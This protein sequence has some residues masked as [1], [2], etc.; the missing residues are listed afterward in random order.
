MPK[1]RAKAIPRRTALPEPEAFYIT[2]DLLVSSRASLAPLAAAL[3]DAHLPMARLLVL[4]GISRGSVETDFRRFIARLSVLR[5]AALRSWRTA[6]RRVLDIGVQAGN[7][8][9]P[10]EGVRL[11]AA[12]LKAAAALGIQVQVTVYR[13]GAYDMREETP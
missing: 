1:T 13:P 7:E 6:G 3:P 2:T 9:H 10:F 5:G 11:S 12:T 8:T 4:N